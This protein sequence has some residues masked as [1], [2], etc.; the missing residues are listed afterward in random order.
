M[1]HRSREGNVVDLGRGGPARPGAAGILERIAGIGQR[2]L[3][4]ALEETLDTAD[5][6]LFDVADKAQQEAT[7]QVY[8]AA[9]R[10]VRLQ[11]RRLL[12]GFRSAL[13]E[14]WQAF[15]D[16]DDRAAGSG[17]GA[18]LELVEKDSLEEEVA[19]RNMA[20]R[21]G[22]HSLQALYLL[23]RRLE[24]LTGR[25]GL[26]GSEHPLH[27]AAVGDAFRRALDGLELL[28]EV[29]LVIYKLFERGVMNGLAALYDDLNEDLVRSGVL[30]DLRPEARR[31][32]VSTTAA[33]AAPGLAGGV[34]PGA[35]GAP[36][37]AAVPAAGVIAA[38]PACGPAGQYADPDSGDPSGAPPDA[39]PGERVP[40]GAWIA[41]VPRGAPLMASLLDLQIRG[42]APDP[43]AG[44]GPRAL[45]AGLIELAG[46]SRQDAPARVDAGNAIRLVSLIFEYILDD[47]DL[48]ALA[49]GLLLRLQIPYVRLALMEPQLLEHRD[50][51][52]R[53]LLN[54][55]A[56]ALG[57]AGEEEPGEVSRMA[58]R[59]CNRILHEFDTDP[60]IFQL[61]LEEFRRELEHWQQRASTLEE[62]ARRTAE[63]RERLA[64]AR[65]R[66]D[67][68]IEAWS[69]RPETPRLVVEFLDQ[70]WRQ[71]LLVVM[72]R[73]GEDSREWQRH[74][75][76]IDG[77]LWSLRPKR[78]KAEIRRLVAILPGLLG[79]LRLGLDLA[80]VHPQVIAVFFRELSRLHVQ[81]ANGG[82]DR[83]W[84]EQQVC[85]WGDP[86]EVP[87][88]HAPEPVAAEPVATEIATPPPPAPAA[89]GDTAGTG[90]AESPALQ[91]IR[92]LEPETWMELEL[93]GRITR[94]KLS[95]RSPV[96][97]TCLLVDARGA[98]LISESQEAL[99]ARLEAGTLRILE[100]APIFD[101]AVEAIGAEPPE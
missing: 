48:P 47:R 57:Q 5:D 90:G 54:E 79:R 35:A 38:G 31:Q 15:V 70:H 44:Y 81:A 25:H 82:L 86:D 7:R 39:R 27:P 42:A 100:E 96:S 3:A 64:L 10:D 37:A 74:V 94:G 19:I 40:A 17:G 50:H 41:A 91:R 34:S 56:R 1:A 69:R 62:R 14:D 23:A 97:G 4:A 30:P 101:R 36:A 67:A 32:P 66:V 76:T 53:V 13:E 29:K 49:R 84:L 73:H 80:S 60:S 89:A 99:A 52:A 88:P 21:A 72:H 6:V 61:A 75:A 55:M 93:E 59:I 85:R 95:W 87:D 18:A 71:T 58:E 65:Q 28:L 8:M 24:V 63:G 68:W 26:D 9:M 51:A 46:R 22:R 33:A 16:G 77:L 11:R 92:A 20:A 98:R 12:A 45:G 78:R 43:A 2:R 83:D